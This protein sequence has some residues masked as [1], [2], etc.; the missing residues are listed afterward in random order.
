MDDSTLKHSI[1][2]KRT[3]T[4]AGLDG[5]TLQDLKAMPTNALQNFVA[6]FHHAE[7]NG[8]WPSQV[9]AGRVSCL[10]KTDDPKHVLDFRPITVLGLLY[11]CWSS[12]N[13]KN[14]IR[15][16]DECLPEGLFG[17]RP[18]CFAGQVWSQLLWTVELAYSNELPLSGII[19]DI[20]KAFNFLPREVVM[21]TCALLGVPFRVLCAWAGALTIMPRRFQINGAFSQPVTSTC[22]LPEGCAL[23][24]VGMM[25]IDVLYHLWMRVFFPLCQPLSYVDDWQILVPHPDSIQPVFACLDRLVD[26]LDLLLDPK[27]TCAWSICPDG[28]T[29]MRE[30]GFT[31]VAYGRNLG[32]HVQ[33]TRQHTNKTLIAVSIV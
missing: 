30:H 23:S 24:C 11:R 13:A 7:A 5:V 18:Q 14:A 1:A 22:G 31:L 28:R 12:Y 16:L 8:A 32:A 15:C 25:A 2:Q 19:A 26:A 6:M 33:F 29:T 4:T 20:R 10:A 17:S 9:V 27:K 21:E 3:N